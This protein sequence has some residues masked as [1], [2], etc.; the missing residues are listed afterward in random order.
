[1]KTKLTTLLLG[2]GLPLLVTFGS[3]H[4]A[5]AQTPQ[6]LPLLFSGPVEVQTRVRP[7]RYITMM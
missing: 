4:R 1:M 2:A 5:A 6:D 7:A 3:T